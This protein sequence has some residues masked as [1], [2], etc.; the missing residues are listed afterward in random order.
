MPFI[1]S[2]LV[3]II[4]CASA[5]CASSNTEAAA[6]EAATPKPSEAPSQTVNQLVWSGALQ[7]M[8]EKTGYAAPTKQQKTY[9]TVRLQPTA[10]DINRTLVNIVVST[11]GQDAGSL[12]WAILPGRCGGATLPIVGYEH[13]P[14]IEVGTNGRGQLNTEIPLAMPYDGSFHVNIYGGGQS[15][16]GGGGLEN[17]L[18]CANLRR[19]GS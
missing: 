17:V 11:S 7:P 1:R 6:G 5:A 15:P 16:S 8:Q 10:R 12:R 2:G 19:G 18:T 14:I 3:G 4:A 13:F 9:G